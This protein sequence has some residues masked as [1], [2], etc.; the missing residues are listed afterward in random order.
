MGQAM[1][2]HLVIAGEK[3]L[4]LGQGH[5]A[6]NGAGGKGGPLGGEQAGI[7]IEGSFHSMV[8]QQLHQ[9]HILFHAVVIAKSEGLRQPTGIAQKHGAASSFLSR[10]PF[11]QVPCLHS[12]PKKQIR[13]GPGLGSSGTSQWGF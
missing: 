5:A 8:V 7:K 1:H 2:R 9:A 10:C 6:V 12:V 3:G 4:A 11:R 13:Q